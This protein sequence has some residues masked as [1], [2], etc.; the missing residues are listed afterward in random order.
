VD[1]G[2]VWLPIPPDEFQVQPLAEHP[3]IVVVPAEHSLASA[4]FVSIEQLLNAPLVFFR[5][6][7]AVCFS[8]DRATDSWNQDRS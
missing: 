4:K 8:S 6:A 1:L 2:F 3:L 5:R 7:R